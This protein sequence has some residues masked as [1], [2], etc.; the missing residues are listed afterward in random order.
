MSDNKVVGDKIT[1]NKGKDKNINQNLMLT[2]PA[3]N[4]LIFQ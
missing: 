1:P 2:L 4:F 3:L